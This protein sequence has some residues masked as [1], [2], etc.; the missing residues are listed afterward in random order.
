MFLRNVAGSRQD[1]AYIIRVAVRASAS[2]CGCVGGDVGSAVRRG[3]V[4]LKFDHIGSERGLPRPG[5][6]WRL[7]AGPCLEPSRDISLQGTELWHV[8]SCG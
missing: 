7:P 1:T 4:D 2:I 6:A 8:A 5:A 3:W